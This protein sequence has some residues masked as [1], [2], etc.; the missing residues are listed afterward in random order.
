MKMEIIIV[1]DETDPGSAFPAMRRAL[2]H[3]RPFP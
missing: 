2:R 3:D 1:F